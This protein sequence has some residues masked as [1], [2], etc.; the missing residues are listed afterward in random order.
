M[1][2]LQILLVSSFVTPDSDEEVQQK[3]LLLLKSPQS[4]V[5]TYLAKDL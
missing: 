2:E 5:L 3:I 1:S 4:E